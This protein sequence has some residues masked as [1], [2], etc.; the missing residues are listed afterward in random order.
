[1]EIYRAASRKRW[2]DVS[3]ILYEGIPGKKTLGGKS[4]ST[5]LLRLPYVSCVSP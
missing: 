2:L 4:P 3:I 5:K 1:M